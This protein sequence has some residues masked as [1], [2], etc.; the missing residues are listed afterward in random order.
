MPPTL[1]K[2]GALTAI[3]AL[4]DGTEWNAIRGMLDDVAAIMI[5]AGYR[6]RDYEP[7]DAGTRM[8]E[9]IE[10]ELGTPEHHTE[11]LSRILNGD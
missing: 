10:S 9:A 1:T 6:I 7:D 11:E 3:Q 8:L 2:E 4:L 5:A